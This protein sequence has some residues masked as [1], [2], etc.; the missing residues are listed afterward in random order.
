MAASVGKSRRRS[1]TERS[2][3][4]RASERGFAAVNQSS[5]GCERRQIARRRTEEKGAEAFFPL[6]TPTTATDPTR[7]CA[8]SGLR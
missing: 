7:D 3:G 4:L 5:R 2:R 1:A 6:R 8:S